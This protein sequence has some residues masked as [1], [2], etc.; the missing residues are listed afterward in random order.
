[1]VI[2]FKL[3]FAVIFF[4]SCAILMMSSDLPLLSVSLDGNLV[5]FIRDNGLPLGIFSGIILLIIVAPQKLSPEH[6]C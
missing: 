6:V 1:M 2:L 4:S 3:L 5:N